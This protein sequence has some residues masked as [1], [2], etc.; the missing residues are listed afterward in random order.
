MGS[1][2]EP[3]AHRPATESTA[4]GV[5]D[6]TPIVVPHSGVVESVIIVE[7]LYAA[8][9]RVEAGEEVVIV[10]SEKAETAIEA[11]ATGT[12]EIVIEADP[13][14]DVE[15]DVGTTIGHVVT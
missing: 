5:S 4:D 15:V 10:E 14:D 11:P 1:P 9:D 12:L 7:W 6:R 3:S 13:H 8:G 2:Q